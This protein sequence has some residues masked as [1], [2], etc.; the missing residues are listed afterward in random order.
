[1]WVIT[2]Q[3]DQFSGRPPTP[4]PG[5]ETCCCQSAL[6]SSGHVDRE[7]K[8][9]KIEL[10]YKRVTQITKAML[11][12]FVLVS[13]W[14]NEKNTVLTLFS[15]V[16]GA[17]PINITWHILNYCCIQG[18]FTLKLWLS[19]SCSSCKTI[20]WPHLFIFGL[21]GRSCLY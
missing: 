10:E 2:T 18:S 14:Q 12:L 3:A 19:H 16:N 13:S 5:I 1:M 21:T 7:R 17:C 9:M 8:K 15:L 20:P 4:R 6:S 11:F